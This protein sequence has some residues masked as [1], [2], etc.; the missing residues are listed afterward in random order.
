M[1]QLCTIF[2]GGGII[3]KRMFD[4]LLQFEAKL[5]ATVNDWSVAICTIET[6]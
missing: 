4:K 3:N 2:L 6:T 5:I 1:Y